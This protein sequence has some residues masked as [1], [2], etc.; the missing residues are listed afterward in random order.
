M[1]IYSGPA[2]GTGMGLPRDHRRPHWF[3]PTFGESRMSPSRLLFSALLVTGMM[4]VSKPRVACGD[5]PSKPTSSASETNPAVPAPGHSVHGEAFSD[6]PRTAARILPGMGKIHFQATTANPQARAFIDQGVG[7]LHSFYYYEAERSFR[8]A[9]KIDPDCATAYW[10]MAMANSFNL[11]RA[12][13]FLAEARKRAGKASRREVLYLDA[14]AAGI[15]ESGNDKSRRQGWLSGLETIVHEFPDDID[16]RAWMV[17]VAWQNAADGIGSR[18]ALDMVLD[19]VLQAEPMHPGAHHYRIHLQDGVKPE[20]ALKSA[21]LYAKS[22]PGIAHAWHM[23]GHTYTGL[24]RYADAAYQQEGSARVDHAAM[25]ADRTMPFEIHNYA[26]NNQWLCTTYSHLG[27]VRDAIAVARNLVEEPRDPSKNGPNDGGS[28]QRSGRARWVEVLTRYELWDELLEADRTGALDWSSVPVE[29]V[30]RALALGQAY[31][32]KS[33]AAGLAKQIDRLKELAA[34]EAKG[35]PRR[36]ERPGQALASS[37]GA[38]AATRSALAELEGLRLLA[39]GDIGA[40]FDQFAKAP[41]MRKEALARAHLKARNYGLAESVARTAVREGENQ[42]PPLAALVEV[43]HAAGKEKDARSTYRTLETVAR[44]ADRDFPAF[45]RIEAVA[46]PWKLDKSWSSPKDA[47]TAGTDE[48]S[49]NRIELGSLGPLLWS[50]FPADSFQL[51]DTAGVPWKLEDQRGKCV[52][53]LFFLGGKCAHC[54]QQLD[55]FSKADQA[56]RSRNVVTAAISTDDAEVTKQLK[57]NKD[58]VAFKMPILA[59]PKL[60]LFKKNHAYDDFECQPL[61]G[62]ILIDSRGFVRYQRISAEPFL[63]VEFIKGEVDRINRLTAPK[64][65]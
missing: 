41:M 43:L 38:T 50:P 63:D 22:A 12:R 46:A 37:D 24:K 3:P 1:V 10:G 15:D 11:K 47:G 62:T 39:A 16:A 21:G 20:R 31:A 57:N 61:H 42:V 53:L 27:R 8:Q 55:L 59:D 18:Q 4:E 9:A 5:E 35:G 51:V 54:M 34:S 48:A 65:K 49:I 14:L 40:A 17:M 29:Q 25:F 33:D 23:P 56:L 64:K 19:S 44:W 60:D 45:R 36:G 58:G 30:Q 6:G 7:Q 13:G 52:L 2:A 26:H 32:A 28:A